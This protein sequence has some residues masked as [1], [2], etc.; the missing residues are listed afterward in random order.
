MIIINLYYSNNDNNTISIFN[1]SK[2]NNSLFKNKNE[3]LFSEPEQKKDL[4][5]DKSS[6]IIESSIDYIPNKRKKM[7]EEDCFYPSSMILN[8]VG[9]YV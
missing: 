2:T 8:I 6:S 7:T 1:N 4:L 5:N 3:E 9:K